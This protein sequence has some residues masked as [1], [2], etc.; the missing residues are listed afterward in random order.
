MRATFGPIGKLGLKQMDYDLCE[1]SYFHSGDPYFAAPLKVILEILEIN[2][3]IKINQNGI[4][5]YHNDNR[6]ITHSII[7][8]SNCKFLIGPQSSFHDKKV[9]LRSKY[10]GSNPS[11]LKIHTICLSTTLSNLTS[12]V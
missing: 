8:F 12:T 7:P 9:Y 5:L 4:R 6:L 10:E 3:A 11:Y 1:M 2:Q